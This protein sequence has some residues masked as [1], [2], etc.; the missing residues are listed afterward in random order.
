M[1]FSTLLTVTIFWM[2]QTGDSQDIVLPTM[3]KHLP[4]YLS[5]ENRRPHKMLLQTLNR[6]YKVCHNYRNP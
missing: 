3:I 1:H 5:L 4:K 2:F 6:I